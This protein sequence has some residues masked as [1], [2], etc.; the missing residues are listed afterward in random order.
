M[1][2]TAPAH[3][4]R[5]RAEPMSARWIVRPAREDDY[6]L[7]LMLWRGYCVALDRTVS[8]AIT[9]GVWR[10]ILAPDEA[11]WC[12]LACEGKSEPIGFANYVLHLHTWSLQTVCYLEDLFV[13][14]AARG[15]GAGR[16]LIDA[17]IALGR[18]HDWR[19]VYWHTHENNYRARSLYDRVVPRTDFVRYDIEL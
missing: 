14:P 18:Q 9:E 10:R 12:L 6:Q 2:L 17:L 19:R 1:V 15:S 3:A 4:L 11:I 7:W 8:H 16:V 13:S 5:V